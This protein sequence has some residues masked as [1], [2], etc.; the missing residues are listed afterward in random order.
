MQYFDLAPN[1]VI[2]GGILLLAYTSSTEEYGPCLYFYDLENRRTCAKVNKAEILVDCYPHPTES[3]I[4][5]IRYISNE[6][7]SVRSVE[8]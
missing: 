5:F 3:G 7:I 6:K 1:V 4:T 2:I 8:S